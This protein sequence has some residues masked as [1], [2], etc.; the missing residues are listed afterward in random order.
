MRFSL[1]VHQ[2]T[3]F[4]VRFFCFSGCWTD[5]YN[6]PCLHKWLLWLCRLV[7]TICPPSSRLDSWR[8][9][10]SREGSLPQADPATWAKKDLDNDGSSRSPDAGEDVSSALMEEQQTFAVTRNEGALNAAFP[11]VPLT[12]PEKPNTVAGNNPKGKVRAAFSES[13]MN[14]LVQRF[15]MQRYL[16][17]AEMKNLA[18][19][20]G[21]TYKQVR[22]LLLAVVGSQ[23]RH[24]YLYAFWSVGSPS[25]LKVKTWFQNRRMKLRRH[26]KDTSWVSERYTT[27][28]ESP[29][30][31]TVFNNLPSHVPTVSS[32]H[33][34]LNYAFFFSWY[35]KLYC[36]GIKVRQL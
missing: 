33:H 5:L 25:C 24:N 12:A 3:I 11:H 4:G 36:K 19:L 6:L 28:K 18:E 20:T 27:S 14:A 23:A 10:S 13:Q 2:D 35:H 34:L 26:Q 9:G 17:P 7:L 22:D 29:L 8:S 31:G 30:R 21:L 15:S 32:S 1:W 16:T